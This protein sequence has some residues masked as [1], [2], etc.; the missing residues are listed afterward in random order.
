VSL[1]R[2]LTRL[3]PGWKTAAGACLVAAVIFTG[4]AVSQISVLDPGLRPGLATTGDPLR[5]LSAGQMQFFTNGRE[6]FEETNFVK[7]P[8][9]D[10]DPGLGPRFNSDSCVSCHAH[11]AVGGTS[12]PVN[13]LFEI[14]GRRNGRNQ[15]PWFITRDGPVREARF[16]RYPDGSPDGGVHNLF[17]ITG[18]SDAPGCN[19]AQENFSNRSNLSFRIPTPVFGAGLIEAISDLSLERNLADHRSLKAS[20]GISGR[21]NRSDNDGTVSRFGWKA[22]VKS[23][24]IFS[25]EAYNVEQGVSNPVFPQER[26]ETSACA[27]S[28]TPEDGVDFEHGEVDDITLFTAFMRFLGP[29]ARGPVDSAAAEGQRVFNNIGCALCHTPSLQTGTVGISALNNK[30]VPLFSDLALHRMGP[31]L[32]DH[33]RQGVAGGDEFRTAPLWGLGQRIFLLHDGRTKDLVEAIQAHA[34]EA[35][36]QYPA[37]EANEVV[38]RFNRIGPEAKQQLLRFLRSL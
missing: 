7:D 17:V 34:S 27:F 12:P 28:L 11:P 19:I 35:N 13:P 15:I 30:P 6:A 31:G 3:S 8:P 16:I 36:S 32:A 33:I 26:D 9:A 2:G 18:R 37:S 29:P 22:Q 20:L 25:G 4:T 21:Y 5:G 1:D 38:R 14:A 23:L 24:H 10:G